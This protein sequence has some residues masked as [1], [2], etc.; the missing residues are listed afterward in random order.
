MLQRNIKFEVDVRYFRQGHEI[1]ME[2]TIEELE[3]EGPLIL[4]KRFDVI[5]E[6]IYGFKMETE[7]EIVNI[8]A[9][10]IGKVLSPSIPLSDEGTEDATHAIIDEDH[11]AYFNGEFVNTPIYERN[12][13]RPKNKL[14]GPAIISQ[15]DTTT[16]VLPGYTAE[17]DKNMN[18]LIKKGDL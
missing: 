17:V 5:H 15:K 1:P 6:Q 11:E 13:L 12:L 10:A 8:R 7:V 14:E 3:K 2:V 4:S 18:I 16:L 9:V